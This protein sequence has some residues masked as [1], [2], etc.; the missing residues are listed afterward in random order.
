M[1]DIDENF[2]TNRTQINSQELKRLSLQ[3]MNMLV[4]Q[5]GTVVNQIPLKK[6]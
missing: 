5:K 6:K 4:D 2:L 3:Y 1:S